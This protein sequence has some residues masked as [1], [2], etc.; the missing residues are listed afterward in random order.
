MVTSYG[1]YRDANKREVVER[2]IKE[3]NLSPSISGSITGLYCL[4]FDKVIWLFAIAMVLP[5]L[6]VEPLQV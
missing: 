1:S 6:Q 3:K 2:D 4:E 5:H